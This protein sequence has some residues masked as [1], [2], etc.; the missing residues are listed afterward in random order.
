MKNN[1]VPAICTQCGATL[2]VDPGSEAAI[3]HYCNTPFIVEKAIHTYNVS[4]QS[5]NTVNIHNAIISNGPTAQ[6]LAKRANEFEKQNDLGKAEEYYNKALDLDVNCIEARI[7]LQNIKTTKLIYTANRMAHNNETASAINFLN[8]S[9]DDS[10]DIS[11]IEQEIEFLQNKIRGKVLFRSK[12]H[13]RFSSM[14]ITASEV[15]V[16]LDE[17]VFLIKGKG[18][19]LSIPT[20]EI[21]EFTAVENINYVGE[22]IGRTVPNCVRVM[23]MSNLCNKIKSI[24]VRFNN[25]TDIAHQLNLQLKN[26]RL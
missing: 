2:S 19:S 11:R 15:E 25:A 14:Q 13:Y 23:Q 10:V 6:N 1:L 7:G 24:D 4:I 8:K 17:T 5:A 16:T 22:S 26:L 9:K 3:C 21:T 20:A 18:K 12:G